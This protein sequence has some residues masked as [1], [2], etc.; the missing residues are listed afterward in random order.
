MNIWRRLKNLWILS[1][2][3]VDTSGYCR[4]FPALHLNKN[5]VTIQK[6]LATIIPPDREDFFKQEVHD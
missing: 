1:G 5:I 3:R 4:E 6:K 2:Y